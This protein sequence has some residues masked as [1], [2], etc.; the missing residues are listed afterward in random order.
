VP[1]IIAQAVKAPFVTKTMAARA[2]GRARTSLGVAARG[3]LQPGGHGER[4][5]GPPRPGLVGGI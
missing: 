2:A 3:A 4:E 5:Q 1:G